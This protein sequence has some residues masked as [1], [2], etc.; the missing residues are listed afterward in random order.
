MSSFLKR[1]SHQKQKEMGA[2]E[3]V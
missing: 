2:N 3:H 1:N